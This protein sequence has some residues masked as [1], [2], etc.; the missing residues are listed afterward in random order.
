L[1]VCRTFAH[2]QESCFNVFF[3]SFFFCYFLTCLR[4]LFVVCPHAPFCC[5]NEKKLD[6]SAPVSDKSSSGA[7]ESSS[8][9]HFRHPGR[10]SVVEQR[11][12]G[13]LKQLEADRLALRA[14]YVGDNAV[15]HESG[16]NGVGG[17]GGDVSSGGVRVG[18]GIGVEN[19]ASADSVTNGVG[20]VVINGVGNGVNGNGAGVLN[21][22]V[23]TV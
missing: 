20:T 10:M 11:P 19:S 15:S 13:E 1:F 6:E 17:R 18:V 4:I 7:L 3:L 12:E 9:V 14:D 23:S 5:R 21:P 16:N 22:R 8:A 2:L